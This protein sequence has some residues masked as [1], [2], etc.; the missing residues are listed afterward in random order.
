M[1]TA[2]LPG[3][4]LGSGSLH[5]LG[6][7]VTVPT[8]DRSR[9]RRSIVHLGVGGFHRAHLATYV[10]DLCQAGHRDWSIVGAGVLPGDRA[11]AQALG[12]QDC[13][14]TLITRGPDTTEV[15]VVG[16]IVEFIHASPHPEA[17]IDTIADPVTQVVS[18]TVT[19][20]GYPV[21]DSTG[22]HLPE[23]PNAGPGS[24]FGILAAGLRERY[25]IGGQGLTVISCD[26]IV[27]N[28]QA[29]RTATVGE[30][31]R[32]GADLAAWVE[33]AVAFPNSMVDRI[34]PATTDA[35]RRWLA[36]HEG[37]IDMWPV[38][39]EPFRQ[40]VIE[41]SFSADRL[42]LEDID[43]IVTGDVEPYELMKLRLL[44]AAHSN[45]AYLAAL[46][47]F[48]TVDAALGDHVLHD[49]TTA[50]LDCEARPVV[51]HVAG[52]D[53]EEYTASLVERFANPNIGDQI[54]RLC[55]DGSAKFPKF[56]LPTIRDQLDL[57]GPI[58]LGA[59]ALAGWCEYLTGPREQLAADPLLDVAAD[60][61]ARSRGDAG[62]FLDFADVFGDDLPRSHRFTGAFT[63]ALRVLRERGVRSAI[64]LT[65]EEAGRSDDRSRD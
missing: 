58:E 23:S 17:L 44:N 56:L 11:M 59:L 49:F 15:E 53:L 19:E 48:D 9:L 62:A 54:A 65:L 42:P 40:W 10:Q 6:P 35:D 14:Y 26:N 33:G 55:L 31:H 30:A 12:P 46:A 61:A 52:I 39:T 37:I 13:L 21:D 3:T 4:S 45:L 7:A 27:G 47:G 57:G 41:D 5:R 50:F 29:A 2:D 8:Y 36:E 1:S 60:H 32:L 25:R 20:G 28:G 34:T 43:V 38:V 22:D 51:P 18:L 16:S 64:E 63:E 24:A